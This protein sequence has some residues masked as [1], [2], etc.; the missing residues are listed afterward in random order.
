MATTPRV[1]VFIPVHNRQHYITTAVDSILA[2]TFE[3]FELLIVD[4]GSTDATLD[5]LAR[6]QD[7]RLRVESN[8]RN[9]GIPATRNRGLELA[10][11]EYIAL[12]DSDDISWPNR[13]ARQVETLDRH[14]D[15]AQIGS[16]CDFMD[17]EG[18][19]INRV[20][21]QPLAA[22]D[23]A[24]SLAFYCAL[25]NRTIMARTAILRDYR[26]REDFPR[27]QDYELHQRLSRT[28]RMA[29]LAD[30]LV[31]GREHGGRFT[32][33]TDALGRERKRE[34]CRRALIEIG[35]TPGEEDLDRHYALARPKKLGAA[36]NKDYLAWAEQWLARLDTANRRSQRHVPE[37]L[38]RVMTERWVE[39]CWH[40]RRQLG[41]GAYLHLMRS[42]LARRVPAALWRRLR[43][44]RPA[45]S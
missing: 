9:L 31:C 34:I 6:Y 28:Q 4:D 36:L 45:A 33:Q 2:Q 38:S 37:A 39:L 24:A 16:A 8:P 15:L 7:P 10:R 5:V 32:K 30:V 22:D 40:A 13:L 27:C 1:T 21:R 29:N 42:P 3:D 43:T 41:T 18:Q 14:S 17:A 23:V 11:G 20:R 25:T 44:P 19:R 12:L 26:Y 35:I